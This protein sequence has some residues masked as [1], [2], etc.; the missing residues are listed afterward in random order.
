MKLIT[1]LRVHPV[2]YKHWKADKWTQLAPTHT[3]THN[4]F[5]S[6][7]SLDQHRSTHENELIY[8]IHKI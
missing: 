8:N 5:A 1:V 6:F 7:C 2:G 4:P 3:R